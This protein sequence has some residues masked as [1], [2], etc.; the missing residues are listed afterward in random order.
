MAIILDGHLLNLD[1]TIYT[2]Y[3]AFYNMAESSILSYF[4]V[5]T[6]IAIAVVVMVI[7][8]R[9]RQGF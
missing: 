7:I 9:K 8:R 3:H 5:G 1:L 2:S 4:L 6:A